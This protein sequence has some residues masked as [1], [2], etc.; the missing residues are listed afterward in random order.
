[1]RV[2]YTDVVTDTSGVP[3]SNVSVSI[4]PILGTSAT[5]KL[6]A[7]ETGEETLN[8]VVTNTLGVFAVWLDEGRYTVDPEGTEPRTIEVISRGTIE[9]IDSVVENSSRAMKNVMDYGAKGD[10]VTDDTAAIELALAA[11]KTS[12]IGGGI[13]LFPG[14]HIVSSELVLDST[15]GIQLQGFAGPNA[16]SS[17]GSAIIYTGSSI[18]NLISAKSSF[19]FGI[20][21]LSLGYTNAAWKGT[22][23]N[24]S[25]TGIEGES[26]ERGLDTQLV[27]LERAQFTSVSSHLTT[28]ARCIALDNVANVYCSAC[29]FTSAVVGVD[30][31]KAATHANV[32]RFIGCRFSEN[33]T[34]H[35]QNS[36]QSW[37]YV[38]CTFEGGAVTE[39]GSELVAV[40]RFSP[41]TIEGNAIS[42]LGCWVG[43]YPTGKTGAI[44]QWAGIGFFMGGSY[45][46]CRK[47]ANI[48][49]VSI[50]RSSRAIGIIGNE[51][52]NAEVG[53][54][55]EKKTTLNVSILA[56]D[57]VSITTRVT[58]E[59]AAEKSRELLECGRSPEMTTGKLTITAPAVTAAGP[60]SA[61]YEGATT[62][63]LSITKRNVGASFAVESSNNTGFINWFIYSE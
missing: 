48:T 30:G 3:Q 25:A 28:I 11:L 33:L 4:T 31:R 55:I 38:G 54:N 16:S 19:G 17:H 21:D 42:F 5:T 35:T 44:I 12:S 58:G 59:L 10:G 51:F 49:L 61:T 27:T 18:T 23:L 63:S 50:T 40:H 7:K 24:L 32:V 13:L 56:N 1:M 43:D 14:R 39:S 57:F 46:A 26:G 37:S 53:I 22:L 9:N 45:V 52:Q 2:E 34:A 60:I 36:G 47:E 62:A 8:S 29:N 41:N 15:T 6:W 20:K